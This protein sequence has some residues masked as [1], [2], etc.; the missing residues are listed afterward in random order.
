[1]FPVATS[2]ILNYMPSPI[3]SSVKTTPPQ[4]VNVSGAVN[5]SE[6]N[7]KPDFK[8]I[9]LPGEKEVSR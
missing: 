8:N 9:P 6:L 3:F 4:E 5:R 7:A 1:M 2:S